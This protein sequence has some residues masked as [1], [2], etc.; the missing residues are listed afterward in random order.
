MPA[1]RSQRDARETLQALLATTPQS[2]PA[3]LPQMPDN[4]KARK[5]FDL[6]GT[7]TGGV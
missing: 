1:S 3:P 6:M 5:K 4:A 2:A 7:L